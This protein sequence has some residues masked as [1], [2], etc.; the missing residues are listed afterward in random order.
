MLLNQIVEGP[1]T[2]IAHR[3]HELLHPGIEAERT[4]RAA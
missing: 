2:S 4:P 3:V 1:A